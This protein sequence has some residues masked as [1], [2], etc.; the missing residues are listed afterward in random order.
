MNG[1]TKAKRYQ[2]E[3]LHKLVPNDEMMD[4]GYIYDSPVFVTEPIRQ[5]IDAAATTLDERDEILWSLAYMSAMNRIAAI[6]DTLAIFR[7]QIS[8]RW[9]RYY[10]EKIGEKIIISR[11]A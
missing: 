9:D 4:L 1:S 2:E 10:V 8:G 3:N 6:S 5:L 7:V 11:K